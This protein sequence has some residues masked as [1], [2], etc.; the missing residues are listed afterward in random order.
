MTYNRYVSTVDVVTGAETEILRAKT[1]DITDFGKNLK[2]LIETLLDTVKKE[3]GV[4]LAAPQIGSSENVCVAKI[5][6]SFKVFV[7]PKITWSSDQATV[8]E[9]GCLSLP[10]VW[11]MIPR[12]EEIVVSFCDEKG[13]QKELKLAGMEARIMQHEVDHLDGVLIVDRAMG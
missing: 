11:L 8:C 9:E 13:E 4:G 3:K 2:K 6:G 10:D 7:N 5:S 12:A 1:Q